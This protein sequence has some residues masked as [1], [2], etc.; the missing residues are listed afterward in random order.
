MSRSYKWIGGIGYVLTF[1]PYVNFVASILVAIAWIMM[2]KDTEEKTFTITG[3]LM[4]ASF[5]LGIILVGILFASLPGLAALSSLKPGIGFFQALGPFLIAF[6][7]TALIAAAVG[8][9][10]FVFE[11]V[12]HFK[13]AKIFDN[14]WFKLAGWFRIALIVVAIISIPLII[15]NIAGLAALSHLAPGPSILG[16]LLSIFWPLIIVLIIGLLSTVFSIVGFFT[17]PEEAQT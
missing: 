1:V 7:V 15:F 10:T 8:L 16:A 5:V 9:A 4:L 2:G 3:A 6:L 13:A 11:V 17:I 14:T 12:S